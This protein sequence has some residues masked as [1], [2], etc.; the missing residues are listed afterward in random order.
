MRQGIEMRGA[1]IIAGARLPIWAV[2]GTFVV[3]ALVG[4]LFGQGTRTAKA[5]RDIPTDIVCREVIPTPPG[6]TL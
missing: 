3:G 6:I 5:R 4:V 1:I 2:V